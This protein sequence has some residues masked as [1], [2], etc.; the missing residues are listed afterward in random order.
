MKIMKKLF[1]SLLII[2]ILFIAASCDK[3]D[4]EGD[5]STNGGST[6]PG[7]NE[8]WIQGSAYNPATITVDAGTTIKWIN[9][10][11]IG[12]TVTSDNNLFDSGTLN[13]N[14]TFSLNFPA[15]G[16]YSYHCIPHPFMTATVVVK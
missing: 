16:T 11:N 5:T 1:I 9:K 14:G 15:A 13:L 2:P 3:D 4:N 12:H 6:G 7:T 10:D 8:V